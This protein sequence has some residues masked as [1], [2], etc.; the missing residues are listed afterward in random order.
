MPAAR[1]IADVQWG[2]LWVFVALFAL[3]TV[4]GFLAPRW[5]RGDTLAHLDGGGLGRGPLGTRVTWFLLGGDLYTAYTFVAVPALV[6]AKGA[7]GLFAIPYTIV[8]YPLV[9]LLMPRLWQI[10]SNRGYVTASDYVNERFDSRFLALLVAITGLVATMPYIALQM[11]G[12]EVVIG[13][14]GIPVEASLIAAFVVLA[15]FTY[16]SGL[17][18]PALIAVVKD[19]LIWATV[20]V[21]IIYIP[22]KLGGFG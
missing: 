10:A 20:I 12:I 3:V 16:V 4:I 2:E 13:Q 22:Y 5:R 19:L 6:F 1:L 18:A 14:M 9:Y 21:A 17:R 8:V 11:Y 7:V 15:L